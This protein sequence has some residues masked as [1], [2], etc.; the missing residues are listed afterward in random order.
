MIDLECRGSIGVAANGKKQV[1]IQYRQLTDETGGFAGHTLQSALGRA[2]TTHGSDGVVGDRPERRTLG[3]LDFGTI[4]LNYF[5]TAEEFFFGELVRFEPGAQLP[6][7]RMAVNGNSYNLLSGR[8][9]DGHEPVRG[10]LYFMAFGNHVAV[11]ERDLGASRLERYLRW[12]LGQQAGIISR[13]SGVVLEAELSVQD[14]SAQLPS[15]DEVVLHPPA[16]TGAK[17]QQANATPV[18]GILTTDTKD[19]ST[20][21]IFEVL[22]AAGIDPADVQQLVENEVDLEVSLQIK[23]KRQRSKKSVTMDRAGRLF[24]NVDPADLTLYSQGARQREGR[25]IKLTR[26]ADVLT[27]GTL[28]DT[29]DVMRA[30]SEAFAWFVSEGYVVA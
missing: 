17:L 10:I 19:V 14:G 27:D 8:V 28:L 3:D 16:L 20:L 9:P 12:L 11:L 30:L 25:L 26:T 7:L 21:R 5:H 1:S 15:V 6:L 24:R 22:A 13:S 23:F 29:K 18:D 2:M 4:L